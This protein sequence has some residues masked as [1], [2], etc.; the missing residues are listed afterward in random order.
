VYGLASWYLDKA[1]IPPPDKNLLHATTLQQEQQP[2]FAPAI[3]ILFAI[4]P[5]FIGPEEV[6][7]P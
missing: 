1:L 5:F 6:I 3:I 2:L 7:F 4:A